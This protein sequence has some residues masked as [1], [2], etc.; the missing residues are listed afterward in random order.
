MASAGAYGLVKGAIEPI[1]GSAIVGAAK[2]RLIAEQQQG[3][4]FVDGEFACAEC[5]EEPGLKEWVSLN[6]NEH[7]CS[8]CG[9]SAAETPVA[10]AVNDL[11]AYIDERLRT[12]Y[13]EA[14]EWYPY[15]SED[16]TLVGVWS[17]SYEL[18]DDLGLFCDERLRDRFID[19]FNS[20]MFCPRYP[21]GLSESVAFMSGWRRFVEHV[22]HHTR[23]YFLSD[24]SAHG[25][26][27]GWHPEELS[28]DEVPTYLGEAIRELELV[29]EIGPD[30]TLFRA[31]LGSAG[32]EFQGARQL[33]TA[34]TGNAI[35][36]NRMS[37]AGIAMFYG[38][39]DRRTAIAEVYEPER[40]P[41][42]TAKASAGAFN[43]SRP[44]HL[45]DLTGVLEL[46]SLFD[47]S[48]SHLREKVLLLRE[49]AEAIAEPVHKG[50]EEHIE[51]VPTQIVTE[52][53]RHVFRVD[54]STPIDGIMYRSSRRPGGVCYVLFVDNEHCVDDESDANDDE[55]RLLLPAGAEQVFGPRLPI[56]LA[57][58]L[59]T[60]HRSQHESARP[61]LRQ[62]P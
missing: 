25:P 43:S 51:Y 23:Y 20:R 12:E 61:A 52:Y 10:V 38:A 54:G 35:W 2:E 57:D 11:F 17:D 19:A 1:T 55:L 14:L 50:R 9:R 49:F 47:E 39:A 62:S 53:F 6:A 15:D 7:A 30:A 16:K 3:W 59:A 26:S 60:K 27:D 36:P 37:P 13:D 8:Y 21:Y 24:P 48:V 28:V 5:V 32:E 44:L 46:P 40:D 22:K 34:P 4:T 18:A 56:W 33:G 42:R 31:R 29:R 58:Q 45:I 41:S